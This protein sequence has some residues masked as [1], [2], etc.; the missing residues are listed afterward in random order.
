[1]VTPQFFLQI[2][3][4]LFL[5]VITHQTAA[6][7]KRSCALMPDGRQ[8]CEKGLPVQNRQPHIQIGLS[9]A[10]SVNLNYIAE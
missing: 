4:F 9:R 6:R 7:T 1:M 3:A 2:S 8:N 5:P 10:E